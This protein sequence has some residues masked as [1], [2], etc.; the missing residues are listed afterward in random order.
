M[1]AI[2]N[3]HLIIFPNIMRNQKGIRT[4]EAFEYENTRNNFKCCGY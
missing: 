1:V 3:F 4:I 2:Y